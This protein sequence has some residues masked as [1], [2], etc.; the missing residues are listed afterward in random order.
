[1]RR[2]GR[3]ESV[4]APSTPAPPPKRAAKPARARKQK[5]R[6]VASPYAD[7]SDEESA[8]SRLG[9]CA[10]PSPR[11]VCREVRDCML[12]L[13]VGYWAVTQLA[14]KHEWGWPEWLA[15]FEAN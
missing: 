6:A 7:E 2:A 15:S 13:I 9:R 12:A 5:C 11:Y 3:R 1:M 4:E 8:G 10:P 14:R